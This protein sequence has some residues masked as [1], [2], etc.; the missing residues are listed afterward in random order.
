MKNGM[1][2]EVPNNWYAKNFSPFIAL[3]AALIKTN[4]S[5]PIA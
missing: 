2:T 1:Q 5:K 4:I 3:S